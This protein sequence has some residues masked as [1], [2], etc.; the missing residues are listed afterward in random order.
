M[1]PKIIWDEEWISIVPL[2]TKMPK[3]LPLVDPM[4]ELCRAGSCAPH[5]YSIKT[6]K[7]RCKKC[8]TPKQYEEAD[9]WKNET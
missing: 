1:K 2:I 5:W 7:L 4:C 6:F 3:N 8:F 9:W